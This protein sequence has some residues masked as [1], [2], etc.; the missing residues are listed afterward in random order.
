[1]E[2]ERTSTGRSIEVPEG[3]VKRETDMFYV[4]RLLLHVSY[5]C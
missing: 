1:M 4:L 5:M 2:A 3:I